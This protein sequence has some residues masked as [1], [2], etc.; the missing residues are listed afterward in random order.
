[1]SQIMKENSA[2]LQ[3]KQL[4]VQTIREAQKELALAE[5]HARLKVKFTTSDVWCRKDECILLARVHHT[6][7]M[8]CP[9]SWVE[10]HQII[11]CFQGK[12]CVQC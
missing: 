5:G 4:I 12:L 9:I 8:L 10:V 3:W 6:V 1:M 11:L 2:A 7:F